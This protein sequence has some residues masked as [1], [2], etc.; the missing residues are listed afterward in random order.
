MIDSWPGAAAHGLDAV[1]AR[2]E[3]V[4][5]LLVVLVV[6]LVVLSL[7][8]QRLQRL[9]GLSLVARSAGSGGPAEHAELR[10]V[11]EEGIKAAVAAGV[12]M[13]INGKLTALQAQLERVEGK[14]DAQFASVDAKQDAQGERIAALEGEL[15]GATQR[16]SLQH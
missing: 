14:R 6:A 11:V 10:K 5:F 13:A 7:V 8:G 9:L 4:P 3:P 1:L 15:R 16:R 12:E 2:L